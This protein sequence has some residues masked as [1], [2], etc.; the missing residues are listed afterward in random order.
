MMFINCD[1]FWVVGINKKQERIWHPC[2]YLFSTA[3]LFPTASL[4]ALGINCVVSDGLLS[5]PRK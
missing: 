3:S 1:M 2:Y 4:V 5:S